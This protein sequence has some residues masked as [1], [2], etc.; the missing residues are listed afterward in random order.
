MRNVPRA[1]MGLVASLVRHINAEATF[2]SVLRRE[3]AGGERTAAIRRLLDTRAEVRASH[4][5]DLRTEVR[6]GEVGGELREMVAGA[7]PALLVV[8]IDGGRAEVEASLARDLA[9]VFEGE[10]ACPLLIAYDAPRG[11]P[12]A[13]AQ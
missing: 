2:L 5:L 12:V 7:D 4:G 9:W 13:L 6:L 8:G 1:V 3:A 10:G 11:R